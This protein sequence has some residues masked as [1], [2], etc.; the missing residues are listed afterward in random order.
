V[1][2]NNDYYYPGFTGVGQMIR[3]SG[4]ACN[5]Y[6]CMD[7]SHKLYASIRLRRNARPEQRRY[8]IVWMVE[9]IGYVSTREV[10]R[11]ARPCPVMKDIDSDDYVEI[12][13]A[14]KGICYCFHS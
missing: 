11:G 10:A 7:T 13:V 2:N 5:G 12:I 14:T 6:G 9:S 1:N 8:P 4:R 3:A